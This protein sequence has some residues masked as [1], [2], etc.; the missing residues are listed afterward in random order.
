LKNEAEIIKLADGDFVKSQ[1][2]AKRAIQE[3]RASEKISSR[4]S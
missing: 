2:F 4:K 3:I 1:P